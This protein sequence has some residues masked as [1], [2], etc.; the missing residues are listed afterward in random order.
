MALEQDKILLELDLGRTSASARE[1]AKEIDQLGLE[2]RELTALLEAVSVVSEQQAV[3]ALNR[4]DKAAEATADAGQELAGQRREG[5]RGILS[6][7]YAIQDFT[8][9][10]DRGFLPALASI[11]N[12]IPGILTGLGVGAGLAGVIS[13]ATVGAGLLANALTGV[14]TEAKAAAEAV[15]DLLQ[16]S[17]K[18]KATRTTEEEKVATGV[19]AYL[20]ELPARTVEQGIRAELMMRAQR[21][22]QEYEREQLRTFGGI[23]ES[24]EEFMARNMPRI[25]ADVAR[26][27]TTLGTDPSS[28]Q[29]VAGLAT[30][31]PGN[32][33]RNFAT[34]I[35]S[36]DRD[37]G[38]AD[39]A[40]AEAFG[41]RAHAGTA[42]RAKA[43]DRARESRRADEAQAER[44]RAGERQGEGLLKQDQE[45]R[46]REMMQS[47]RL[48]QEI[49]EK[50]AREEE[51]AR[52]KAERERDQF[53]RGEIR[54]TDE[55]QRNLEAARLSNQ[56]KAEQLQARNLQATRQLLAEERARGQR[57]DGMG[58]A[59]AD[60]EAMLRQGRPAQ[61]RRAFPQ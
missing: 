7:S 45:R 11:Q 47:A 8:S 55:L 29:F 39:L 38:D 18:L 2:T 56:G 54:A 9:Q 23:N 46:A 59:M 17:E 58:G 33:P 22:S 3:P 31:R 44:E 10:I 51:Q 5:G 12:N 52:K 28:R 43:R 16:A 50:A 1:A 15:K 6:V 26:L 36:F 30:L 41:A 35:L 24:A 27:A 60:V 25:E 53:T 48:R 42:A 61:L 40:A 13:T 57:L 49:G 20:K 32:F 21:Q 34:D 19:G 37:T 4:L 14:G